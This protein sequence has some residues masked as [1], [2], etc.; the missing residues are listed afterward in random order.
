M[1][2]IAFLP[3]IIGIV[4]LLTLVFSIWSLYIVL[5]SF[6]LFGTV[7]VSILSFFFFYELLE[8]FEIDK[9]INYALSAVLTIL[10]GYSIY[11]SWFAI[12]FLG[13]VVGVAWSI[14]RYYKRRV[15]RYFLKRLVRL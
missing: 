13:I 11:Q 1:K 14:L 10:L 3:L 15:G 4:A 5:E 7:F 9:R 8:Y 6:R 2:G 12:I